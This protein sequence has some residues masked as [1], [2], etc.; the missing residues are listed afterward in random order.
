MKKLAKVKNKLNLFLIIE[1]TG[2]R[3]M[4]GSNKVKNSLNN[5]SK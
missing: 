4:T 5:K 1:H 2:S 3:K